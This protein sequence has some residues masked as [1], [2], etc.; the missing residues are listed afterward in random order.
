M[1]DAGDEG[2][3]AD[4]AREEADAEDVDP[5]ADRSR[6]A[7]APGRV[8]GAARRLP[9]VP[10]CLGVVTVILGGLATWFGLEAG[11]VGNGVDTHNVAL[12]NAAATRE[13]SQ[14]VDA[15][16]NTIFSYNY[17]NTAS[18]RQA[19][20]KLLTGKASQQYNTLFKLV[21]A[22]APQEKLVLT[23]TVTNSGVESLEGNQARLLIFINQSDTSNATHKTTAAGAM[24]AV[25]AVREGGSWKIASIDD[26]AG[27]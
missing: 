2:L 4:D 15:A 8:A 5:E 7:A 26:F 11:S 23:T 22:D 12:V 18:T 27:T 13:V 1:P 24:F 21:T 16:V 3:E 19:A 9:L 10:V 6:Q 20:A 14:Q 25:S 17:A